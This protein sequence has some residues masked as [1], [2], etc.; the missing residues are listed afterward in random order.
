MRL[1]ERALREGTRSVAVIA[2]SIG[3]ASESAFSN[4][5][6]R[7]TG[8]SPRDFRN[9]ARV[10]N[11]DDVDGVDEAKTFELKAG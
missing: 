6:K 1:A 11:A 8:Q 9:V 5:F 4:A 10:V 7:M 3:Y 2:E